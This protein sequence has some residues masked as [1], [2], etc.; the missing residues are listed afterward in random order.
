LVVRGGVP[1]SQKS[2]PPYDFSWAFVLQA[3]ADGATRLVVRERYRY[4]RRWTPLMIEP[5]QV[6]SFVMTEK[7]LRGIRDRAEGRLGGP[8]TRRSRPGRSVVPGSG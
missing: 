5:V 3:R 4:T 2:A 6:V 7:M 8:P 1:L